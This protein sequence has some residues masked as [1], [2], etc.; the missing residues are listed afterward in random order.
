MQPRVPMGTNRGQ[1]K[2]LMK[3][4]SED[5]VRSRVALMLCRVAAALLSALLVARLVKGRL[6]GDPGFAGRLRATRR[7]SGPVTVCV[8][9]L[10]VRRSFVSE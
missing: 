9:D 10:C 2:L 8:W 3:R 4:D 7:T 5:S 6:G 1:L